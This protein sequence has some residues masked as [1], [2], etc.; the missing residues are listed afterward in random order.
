[1]LLSRVRPFVLVADVALLLTIQVLAISLS[2]WAFGYGGAI[3]YVLA[4]WVIVGSVAFPASILLASIAFAQR[5]H[6]S[7][8][9]RF[10]LCVSWSVSVGGLY[11]L[12]AN[13]GLALQVGTVMLL[14]ASTVAVAMTAKLTS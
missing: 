4:I 8:R 5:R 11:L 10:W 3:L 2:H 14:I 13:V 6:V 9:L 12:G 7:H 1:M